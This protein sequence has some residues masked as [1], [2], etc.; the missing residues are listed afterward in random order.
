M[1]HVHAQAIAEHLPLVRIAAVAEERSDAIDRSGRMLDGAEVFSSAT[2]ALAHADVAACVVATPTDTHAQLVAAALDRGLHVFCEKPLTLDLDASKR[3][4]EQAR[5]ADRV[6][7]VGFWRRFSP[8]L[9]R[10]KQLLG[11]G[12]IGAAVFAHA[13]QWDVTAPAAEWCAPA[14]S[15]GIFVDMGVHELDEL[16]WLL[17]DRV[18]QVEGR[19]FRVA[20][21]AIGEVGDYDNAA[22]AL[23]FAGGPHGL[24]DLSRN[25]RYADDM[26]LELLGTDG[27]IFVDTFPT[28]RVRVGTREGL[29]TDWE[30][31]GADPFMAGVVAELAAFSLAARD[32]SARNVPGA[33][34]SIRATHLGDLAR[35][36]AD[37]GAPVDAVAG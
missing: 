25:G 23:R 19:A 6:L 2:D 7:Q 11:A 37:M 27:A 21:P 10:A 33:A 30:D 20:D 8:A 3:L 32:P 4:G 14:R 34:E 24:I 1:G 5:R 15:G 12:A 17:D 26:R 16:E 22:M 28:A 13:S 9:I 18:A 31:E 35:R 36:S 29:Q